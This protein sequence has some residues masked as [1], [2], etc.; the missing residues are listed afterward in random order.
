[1]APVGLTVVRLVAAGLVV[2]SFANLRALHPGFVPS[3]VLTM[4][5]EPGVPQASVNE[6]MRVLI[7]RVANLPGVDAA[8]AVYRRPLALGPIGQE[9][10]VLLEGQ[11]DTPEAARRNPALNY[12]VATPG[13]F[14][15]G[16]PRRP[17]RWRS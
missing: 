3:N 17:I 10:A 4:H 8:G 2:R 1:M 7:D 14:T 9:T 16:A 11:P 5:L 12:Q 13:Y 15:A 6:W